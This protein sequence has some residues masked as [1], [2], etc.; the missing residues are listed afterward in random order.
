ME[1]GEM[2]PVKRNMK[3]NFKVNRGKTVPIN[4]PLERNLKAL[5]QRIQA[6]SVKNPLRIADRLMQAANAAET[7][8]NKLIEEAERLQGLP[9]QRNDIKQGG[10]KCR[11]DARELYNQMFELKA[12]AEQLQALALK[13]LPA[14]GQEDNEAILRMQS[15]A[16]RKNSNNLRWIP[17]SGPVER[18]LKKRIQGEIE[19][20]KKLEEMAAEAK[21]RK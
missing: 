9:K 14:K 16:L 13:K 21:K 8:A 2:N 12:M 5:K 18:V 11:A 3:R 10:E 19:E 4:R 20:A 6:Q 15:H 7:R 17:A 1:D